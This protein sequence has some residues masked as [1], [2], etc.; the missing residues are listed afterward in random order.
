MVRK[1]GQ[2]RCPERHHLILPSECMTCKSAECAKGKKVRLSIKHGVP[3]YAAPNG[4]A[5][6]SEPRSRL[7]RESGGDSR[8]SSGRL[9]IKEGRGGVYAHVCAAC[10]YV[11]PEDDLYCGHCGKKL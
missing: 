1:G 8:P 11:V 3:R 4:A 7:P 5:A 10:L 6:T 9:A 2:I